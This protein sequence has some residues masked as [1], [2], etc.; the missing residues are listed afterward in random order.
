[1]IYLTLSE[2]LHT[3]ERTLG[4]PLE[5]RDMGLL[6]SALAR[7][8]ATA[9]GEDAYPD[10]LT[11]AAALCH[12]I[13][14]NHALVDGN[15]RLALAGLLAFLGVNGLQL[16]F[17]ND[18]VFDFIYGIASGESDDVTAIARRLGDATEPFAY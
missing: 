9:L 14:R 6:E 18:E 8:Q 5:I 7:P 17:S 16:S 12:S 10:L 4:G 11:K 15:K 1:M 3:G 2:L 13:A